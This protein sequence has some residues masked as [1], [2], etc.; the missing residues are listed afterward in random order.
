MNLVIEMCVAPP[1]RLPYETDLQYMLI[2][3]KE[4]NL[5]VAQAFCAP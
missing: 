5:G 4:T 1:P 2:S 3:L